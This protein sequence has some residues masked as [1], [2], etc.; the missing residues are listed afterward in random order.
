MHLP[1]SRRPRQALRSQQS[2]F[3][4]L[5][6]AH[7]RQLGTP[8]EIHVELQHLPAKVATASLGSQSCCGACSGQEWRKNPCWRLSYTQ[9]DIGTFATAWRGNRHVDEIRMVG[10]A[11]LRSSESTKSK[12][13]V[14]RY[15][16]STRYGVR[17]LYI[18]SLDV[19]NDQMTV[20]QHQIDNSQSYV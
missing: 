6:A 15:S 7:G 20:S 19:Q 18:C 17:V 14:V 10:M 2:S 5:Q 13:G 16:D 4:T 9:Y 3:A 8:R 12:H 1:V 11:R